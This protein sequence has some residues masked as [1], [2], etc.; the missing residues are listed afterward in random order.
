MLR[1]ARLTSCPP[2]P[3]FTKSTNH[4][5]TNPPW[6][7]RAQ[8]QS[9]EFKQLEQKV[10]E[11]LKEGNTALGQLQKVWRGGAISKSWCLGQLAQKGFGV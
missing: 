2:R 8:T 9:I 5:P 10:V 4:Q 7:V 3:S 1:G 6:P 11:G